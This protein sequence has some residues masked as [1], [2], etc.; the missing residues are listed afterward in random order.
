MIKHLE[1]EDQSTI[2]GGDDFLDNVHDHVTMTMMMIMKMNTLKKKT[3]AQMVGV[4]TD[5]HATKK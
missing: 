5:Q 3:P 2:G 4:M 1:E